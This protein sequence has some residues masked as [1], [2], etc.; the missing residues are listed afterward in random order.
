MAEEDQALAGNI[1]IPHAIVSGLV[2]TAADHVSAWAELAASPEEN[3]LLLHM[4]ADYTLF[5]PVLEGLAE[6]I[7]IL[8][9][10]DS[11]SPQGARDRP[12]RV[13]ARAEA[14]ERSAQSSNTR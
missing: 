11:S 1:V 3:V 5:R 12:H 13:Q 7:W 9:G 6:L 2:L 14:D 8:D 4:Q 10:T